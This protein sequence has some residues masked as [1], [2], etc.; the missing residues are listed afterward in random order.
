MLHQIWFSIENVAFFRFSVTIC[1]FVYT[2]FNISVRVEGRI[3]LF[4]ING[5]VWVQSHT[6][7]T[8]PYYCYIL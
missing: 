3:D 7:L 5:I 1:V 2:I 6:E 4:Y 8:T